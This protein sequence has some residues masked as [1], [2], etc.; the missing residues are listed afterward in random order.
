MSETR[1]EARRE[2]AAPPEKVFDVLRDPRG[3]VS[4]DSSGMLQSAEGDPANGVGDTFVVHMDREA[5]G[6]MPLGKYDVTVTITEYEPGTHIEWTVA[7]GIDHR[8]GYVL[9][10][11]ETG[12][13][14]ISYCDWSRTPEK[15]LNALPFPVV[16]QTSL[17]AT[18]GILA[19]T[20]E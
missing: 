19:R 14:V 9:E 6:D 3:H 18:L 1:I 7:A 11:T 16:P 4:I 8:Y 12:T 17:R 13:T 15:Y 20:V 10:P 5:L 2:I